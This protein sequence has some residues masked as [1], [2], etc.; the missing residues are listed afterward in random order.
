MGRDLAERFPAAR[1]TFAAVDEA[2]GL[3]LSRVMWGGPEEELTRT[4]NAQPAIVTHTC[5]V[6]AAAGSRLEPVAAA[7]VEGSRSPDV[8]A[9]G[10]AALRLGEIRALLGLLTRQPAGTPRTAMLDA[11]APVLVRRT[12]RN[13]LARR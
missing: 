12:L 7:F 2:L 9:G 13:R 1:D 8:Q 3:P 5:A 11:F 4:E 6:L 10:D